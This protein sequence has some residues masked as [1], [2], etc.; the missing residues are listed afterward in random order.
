MRGITMV[1]SHICKTPDEIK[2]ETDVGIG[3][4]DI[5]EEVRNR[6]IGSSSKKPTFN[7]VNVKPL[8]DGIKKALKPNKK[9]DPFNRDN[10]RF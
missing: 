4:K 3:V 2:N 1:D 5:P 7:K 6:K 10:W 9:D 8:D